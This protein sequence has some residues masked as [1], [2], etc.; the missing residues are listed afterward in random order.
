MDGSDSSNQPPS[1]SISSPGN[2]E[3]FARDD[4]I[5][6]QG[7]AEDSED[8]TLSGDALVWES[9]ADGRFGTGE[10]NTSTLSP[11]RHTVTLTATDSRGATARDTVSVA[12][13]GPPTVNIATPDD[14]SATDEAEMLTLEGSA[15]D[16]VDGELSENRL[17][18]SSDVDGPL[19]T[20]TRVPDLNLSPGPHTI[21]LTATDQDGN[22]ASDSI[23]IVIESPG[24]DVRLRFLS[25]LT[26]S[27]R[28]T[29]RDA[30]APWEDVITGDLNPVFPGLDFSNIQQCPIRPG[31]IDDL[32]VA[33]DVVDLDGPGGTLAQAAPCA[34]RTKNVATLTTPFAGF[35]QI[36]EADLDNSRLEK[37]VTHEVGHV[38]GIGIGILPG[39]EQSPSSLN[40]FDPFHAGSNTSE[41]FDQL[42]GDAYLSEGV[43]LE[44]T[45]GQGTR[46]AH[47][48]EVNFDNELM[49]GFINPNSDLPLSRVSLASLEDLGYD[50]DLSAAASF[51][52][53]MPQQ[54][55][56]LADADAT[57]SRPVSSNENFGFPEGVRL[58]SALVAGSNNAQLWSSDPESEVFSGLVRFD[59]PSS[60]PMGV[61]VEQAAIRLVVSDRNAETTDHD[62]GIFPVESDW[63]EDTV[64]WEGRPS[65]RDSVESFDFQS[66]DQCLRDLTGLAT[67][68]VTGRANHGVALRAPD[69]TSDSTFSV[70]FF[71]RHTPSAIQRPL[72]IVLAQTGSAAIRSGKPLLKTGEP[73][74]DEKIPLGDDI[75]E[76]TIYGVDADGNIVQTKR[77]R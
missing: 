67:D 46:G 15:T 30:V 54:T 64:T 55:I 41:A 62:V 11:D 23:E 40:T 12:V 77:I 76:G 39:W 42:G 19:G 65:T 66:C 45:G 17:E 27:Q 29:I 10:Q 69:A 44:N 72:V 6:F 37:I 34:A 5:A 58:D 1:V 22:A 56:W 60:L 21:M 16:P 63:S 50:V 32:V 33:V 13:N 51:D 36:D 8:G 4:S 70:G 74:S 35:V 48:R 20:G 25:D 14:E 26:S 61:T 9:S 47:W 38:L 18:W 59:T 71:N 28:T 7:S 52:L 31:G 3:E 75:L 24:F 57:L 43:P 49:T 2:G 53:P 68:W 73:P